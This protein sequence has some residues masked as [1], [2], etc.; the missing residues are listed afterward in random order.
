MNI[1]ALQGIASPCICGPINQ[2]AQERYEKFM[3]I[4]NAYHIC[5]DV[6]IFVIEQSP[7]FSDIAPTLNTCKKVVDTAAKIMIDYDLQESNTENGIEIDWCGWNFEESYDMPQE[8]KNHF[9]ALLDLFRLYM[10]SIAC[11][12]QSVRIDT[13]DQKKWTLI[14]QPSHQ[15]QDQP[16]EYK[17]LNAYNLVLAQHIQR[18]RTA[19]Q[20]VRESY[21][22]SG[23]ALASHSNF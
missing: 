13:G 21:S 1:T 9:S 14:Q 6:Q 7:R 19:M 8:E 22:V 11:V 10:Q 2:Q 4:W 17:A 20:E 23:A 16:Q 15:I 3:K 12:S 18:L 5:I